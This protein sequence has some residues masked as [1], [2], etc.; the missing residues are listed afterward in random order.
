MTGFLP[1]PEWR[2]SAYWY[3]ARAGMLTGDDLEFLRCLG[4]RAARLARWHGI[5]PQAVP[6]GPYL[7]HMWPEWVWDVTV[8]QMADDG[9]RFGEW[10]PG[11]GTGYW[12]T[13]D[14]G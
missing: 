1:G 7:V 2:C 4:L 14:Y 13:G 11:T 3:A 8:R 9:A 5:P 10:G 12:E 6:E